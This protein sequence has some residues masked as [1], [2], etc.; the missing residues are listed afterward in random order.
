[1]KKREEIPVCHTWNMADILPSEEAWEN[2]FRETEQALSGYKKYEG[3]LADSG[4]MLF[5]CLEFDEEM[6]LK[7]ETLFVYGRQK[8]DE[9]T[10]NA[11]YQEFSSRARA[12]SYEAAGM[13]SFIVPEIL[14]IPEE[15]LSRLRKDTEKLKRYDRTFEI[16]LKKKAHTLSA[17]MEALLAKSMDATSGSSDVFNMFNNADVKFPEILDENKEPVRITHG[18]YIALMEKQNREVRKSAFEG[19]YSVYKQFGNTLASTFA[20]NLKRAAFYAQARN[21]PSARA[22]SLGENEVPEEVY[23]NLLQAVHE[24]LPLLHQYV[25]I[26]KKALGVEEL[27][28]YDL[29]VPMVSREEQ[30]FTFEGAKAMVL[31]GLKPLGEEYL[32]LLK[33][34]FENRWI[35]VYE[36]EGKRSGAYSWGVYGIHPYVLLNFNGTLDSVFTLAHE[37]GHALH[38]WFSDKHRTYVDAAYKIFVAEVASTCNEALL[39]RHLLEITEDKAERAYLVNHF[40]DS[41]RGT[42]YRQAMF[43]EFEEETHRRL[44]K[45]EVLTAD[46]LC[47]I[48]RRLNE[49]Y[50]GPDMIVDREIDYEWSRIPHFYTPFYVYQYAT[51][52]SAAIAISSKILEG[53]EKVLEGYYQFLS[54]GNSMTPIDLLKLCGVDMSTSKPVTDALAVFSELLEEMNRLI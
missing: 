5:S 23:D 11:R 25:S 8:S 33:E 53:D 12:L 20:S 35:D 27:H 42:L 16:I 6:S 38:S 9:N 2:L 15:T 19:L 45:G 36:N 31:E 7:I 43:A 37:M 49:E 50:F 52:F 48:Y 21:Y 22:H 54:G 28:M 30:K 24:G 29:Y 17:S 4:E 34:G 44:G 13:S 1:M 3:H 26:R 41:F 32:S 40:M 51:G 39:I 14:E 46:L 10:G 47:S 18:N